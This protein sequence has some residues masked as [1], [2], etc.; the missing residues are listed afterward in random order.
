MEL[1]PRVVSVLSLVM[2]CGSP[3]RTPPSAPANTVRTEPAPIW[4]HRR[5]ETSE[6]SIRPEKVTTLRLAIEGGHATLV[7][8]SRSS[9]RENRELGPST[10]VTRVGSAVATETGFALDF[11]DG[12]PLQLMCVRGNAD[13]AGA[14]AMR[15]ET[16]METGDTP[17]VPAAT[18]SVAV[19]RCEGLGWDDAAFA[20]PPGVESACA[21]NVGCGLRAM[22]T[23][24]SLAPVMQPARN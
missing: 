10:R 12:E 18:T 8:D 23:D 6:V 5:Y 3:S 24:G 21:T 9:S 4:L 15:G 20:P 1:G 14:T 13:V 2:A 22:A 17:W 16:S 11:V 7:I 19:L